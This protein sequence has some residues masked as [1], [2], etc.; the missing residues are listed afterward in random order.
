MP[1]G[2]PWPCFSAERH[3]LSPLDRRARRS[4]R[5]RPRKWRRAPARRC[6]S[7]TSPRGFAPAVVNIST[8]QRVPV[9]AQQD[10][11]EEFFRRFDPNQPQGDSGGA[12]RR[13]RPA[14][15]PRGGLARLGLHRFARRLRRHQ[16]PSDPGPDR[17]R[18]RRQRHH[19]HH[20]RQGISGPDRRPRRH[21]GPRAA[22]DRRPQ[23][24]V[25]AVGRQHQGAGR[26]LG[27]AIGN[28]YGLGGTV[29]AGIVSAIHRGIPGATP[30]PTT[31]TFRPTRPSTWAIAAARCSISTA[32]S[33]ASTRR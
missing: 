32:M 20:Q 7:P 23:P 24:A 18:D 2:S 21:L 6:R 33:S 25:R 30:A 28:P 16:Q 1:M 27:I 4:P 17:H 3:F 22:Q 19:H 31:A 12:E 10:P 11:F 15:D 9:R 13:R 26:R 29:T 5:T 8:K 14:A